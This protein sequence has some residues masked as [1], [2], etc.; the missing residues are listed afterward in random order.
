MS[1]SLLIRVSR[2]QIGAS[3][4]KIFPFLAVTGCDCLF[5]GDSPPSSF[6]YSNSNRQRL[7]TGSVDK[8]VIECLDCDPLLL[9]VRLLNI[10]VS[11]LRQIPAICLYL[12]DFIQTAP[13]HVKFYPHTS[14]LKKKGFLT[15]LKGKG[16]KTQRDLANNQI[17]SS[18]LQ[19]TG[20]KF[21][22]FKCQAQL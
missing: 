1:T 22:A 11:G 17:Y 15:Y 18:G 13:K 6:S 3:W 4:R 21:S 12:Y 7:G 14:S 5:S 20:S 9:P 19:Q 10:H 8:L 16:I 2:R